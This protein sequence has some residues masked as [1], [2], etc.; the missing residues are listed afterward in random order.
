MNIT[1]TEISNLLKTLGLQQIRM[2]TG[3]GKPSI[4]WKPCGK[5]VRGIWLHSDS[6]TDIF[7]PEPSIAVKIEK[8]VDKLVSLG[9]RREVNPH[10]ERGMG[11]RFVVKQ[12]SRSIEYLVL[13]QVIVDKYTMNAGYDTGYYVT[14]L[15]PTYDTRIVYTSA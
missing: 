7:D 8:I 15:V 3:F 5:S 11:Y 9:L 2:S 13:T 1:K 10:A 6:P 12:T 14:Y 4:A